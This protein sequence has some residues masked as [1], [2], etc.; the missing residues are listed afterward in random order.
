MKGTAHAPDRAASADRAGEGAARRGAVKALAAP[1]RARRYRAV[2]E[3]DEELIKSPFLPG[4]GR[5]DVRFRS[6]QGSSD[7]CGVGAGREAADGA[8]GADAGEDE[9]VASLGSALASQRRDGGGWHTSLGCP[10][11]SSSATIRSH[12]ASEYR[13]VM[14]LLICQSLRGGRPR[15]TDLHR[16]PYRG[17]RAN[18][19]FPALGAERAS[20]AK[21]RS[22]R[23][24]TTGQ[25]PHEPSSPRAKGCSVA[26][27]ETSNRC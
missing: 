2:A 19:V 8:P 18:R 24:A 25:S 26:Q 23:T 12:S 10:A 17:Y 1:L 21:G 9:R 15:N 4:Y 13:A 16:P 7:I 3:V 27:V 6:W 20:V 5:W 14:Y 22:R 11:R